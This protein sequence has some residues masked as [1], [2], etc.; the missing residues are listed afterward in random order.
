VSAS[1]SAAEGLVELHE[2]RPDVVV[3]DISLPA[4]DGYRLIR[5]I[6]SSP[7]THERYTPAIALTAHAGEANRKRA[8]DAGY[9]EHLTKPADPNDLVRTIV[10]LTRQ[11]A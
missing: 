9:Q 1:A 5:R 3:A 11:A 7:L 8:L 6:R 4:E 10:R 2:F